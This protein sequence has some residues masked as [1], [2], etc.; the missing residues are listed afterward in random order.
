MKKRLLTT[1]VLSILMIAGSVS[2]QS[3]NGT[4]TGSVQDQANFMIPGATIVLT[5]TKTNATLKTLTNESGKY[6][7]EAAPGTYD[8]TAALTGFET[9]KVANILLDENQSLQ[10]NLTLRIGQNGSDVTLI[11]Q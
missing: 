10:L 2:A 3:K 8:L 6:K 1:M 4:I 5:N 11:G 7:L 9:S